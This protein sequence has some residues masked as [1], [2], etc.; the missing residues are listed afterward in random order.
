LFTKLPTLVPP[1]DEP[2]AI[3]NYLDSVTSKIEELK[4][5]ISSGINLLHE[6][7]TALISAAATG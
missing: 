5:G 3:A 6:Y 2:E 1:L 7:R 4:V